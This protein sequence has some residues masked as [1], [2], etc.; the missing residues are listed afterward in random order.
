MLV[1][2]FNMDVMGPVQ[3]WF[4]SS[5]VTQGVVF[6]KCNI[7]I[8]FVQP[9]LC[10]SLLIRCCT[11]TRLA[12]YAWNLKWPKGHVLFTVKHFYNHLTP[13]N[14]QF[15][16]NTITWKSVKKEHFQK[17]WDMIIWVWYQMYIDG[18]LFRW[19]LSFSSGKWLWALGSLRLWTAELC[20]N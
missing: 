4:W 12:F 5:P 6:I 10:K 11:N 9:E 2:I 19:V 17:S 8:L 16:H 14:L 13:T 3:V 20:H 18:L 15:L 1:S 7:G